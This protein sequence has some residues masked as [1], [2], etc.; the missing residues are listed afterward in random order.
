MFLCDLL[1]LLITEFIGDFWL[2]IEQEKV[3][4][5]GILNLVQFWHFLYRV[6]SN[7]CFV[8]YSLHVESVIMSSFYIIL[9]FWA[10]INV[11]RAIFSSH[12]SDFWSSLVLR[13][14]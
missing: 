7:V 1:I 6:N 8:A 10:F 3:L 13:I 4:D 2:A 12:K 14:A 5:L 9:P 11:A